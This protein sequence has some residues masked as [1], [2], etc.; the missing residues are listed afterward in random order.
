MRRLTERGLEAWYLPPARLVHIVPASKVTLKHVGD[1]KRAYGRYLGRELYKTQTRRL[2]VFNIPPWLGRKLVKNAA[3]WITAKMI[4]S[5]IAEYLELQETLGTAETLRIERGHKSTKASQLPLASVIIPAY[6]AAEHIAGALESV[7]AQT[8]PSYEVIV[9]NDGSPDT[10]ALEKAL[11][12]YLERMVYIRQENGG[13]SAARNAGIRRARGAFLAFLDS[14][15]SWNPEFLSSQMRCFEK[16]P[17]LDLVY[18]D[19]LYEGNSEY[20]GK[21]YMQMFPPRGR[22]TFE[23]LMRREYLIFPSTVVLRKSAAIGAGLF[24]EA[25]RRSEDFDL[26]VRIAH[27]RG[28]I[29]YHGKVLARR[30][31]HPASLSFVGARMQ[32]AEDDVLRKLD[33]TLELT[34]YQRRLLRKRMLL[35]VARKQ[36]V[37]GS[38][39]LRDGNLAEAKTAYQ[40]AFRLR[41]TAKLGL[42]L[43]GLRIAPGLTR[44]FVRIWGQL[45][46]G[47]KRF[48]TLGNKV[49]PQL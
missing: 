38:D 1:R 10:P 9:I 16:N 37:L 34:P 36:V 3:S 7:F 5:G 46:P 44:D 12:P 15:D 31:V 43:L 49:W 48:R 32:E 42:V 28:R 18:S 33:K 41:P 4:G 11:E 8:Y 25:I 23:N 27:R 26:F 20:S 17:K 30:L 6:N 19:F 40:A 22:V 13:P 39:Y 21:S 45:L 47:L 29:A 14:D 2:P 35:P 24:D